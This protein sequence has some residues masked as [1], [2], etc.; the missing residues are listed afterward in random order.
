MEHTIR[1][2][3]WNTEITIIE[4]VKTTIKITD[5][6]LSETIIHELTDNK[7]FDFIGVLLHIQSKRRK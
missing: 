7:L 6:D 5:L 3:E 1:N 2:K 4:G